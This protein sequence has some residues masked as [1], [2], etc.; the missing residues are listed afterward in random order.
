MPKTK[1]VNPEVD[2]AALFSK[3]AE[4]TL[5]GV[6]YN[7]V[8]K[9]S[10]LIEYDDLSGDNSLF[11]FAQRIQ[12]PTLKFLSTMLYVLLKRAGAEYTLDDVVELVQPDNIA[13]ISEAITL[14]WIHANPELKAK[15]E[16]D[17]TKATDFQPK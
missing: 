5:E 10:A 1:N 7:L 12:R 2:L 15:A 3:K 17:P 13:K 4:L 14:A 8:L 16:A 6:T 9:N 11:S